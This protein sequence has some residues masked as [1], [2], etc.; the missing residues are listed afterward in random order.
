MPTAQ[1]FQHKPNNIDHVTSGFLSKIM[2]TWRYFKHMQYPMPLSRSLST[3]QSCCQAELPLRK[4]CHSGVPRWCSWSRRSAERLLP[5]IPHLSQEPP[6]TQTYPLTVKTLG[7]PTNFENPKVTIKGVVGTHV[8]WSLEGNVAS[9]H[10]WKR[11]RQSWESRKNMCCVDRVF[12]YFSHDPIESPNW[13]R[14]PIA[15]R[16]VWSLTLPGIIVASNFPLPKFGPT[17]EWNDAEKKHKPFL[18]QNDP[19]LGPQ[20]LIGLGLW[21]VSCMLLECPKVG[22]SWNLKS[23][24][25][26]TG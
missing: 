13:F 2:L 22:T 4:P 21:W 16:P 14:K 17:G 18:D 15:I 5:K 7:Y 25:C 8:D 19:N 24:G 6:K 1:P 11:C 10:I 12:S 23:S 20:S 3:L 26:S 9:P